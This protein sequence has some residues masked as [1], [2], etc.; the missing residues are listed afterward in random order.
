MKKIVLFFFSFLVLLSSCS[1]EDNDSN[2]EYIPFQESKGGLWGMISPDGKILFSDEF[3]NEPTVAKEGRFMVRNSSGLWE[4]YTCEAKPVKIGGE[5]VYATCFK[6]GRAIVAERNGY[7]KVIDRQG[8]DIKILDKINNH[9]VDYLNQFEEGCAVYM[10]DSLYGA[11]DEDFDEVIKPVYAELYH[12][13]DGKFIGIHDKYRKELDKPEAER[14][15][16]YDVLNTKGDLLFQLSTEKY[17][18]FHESPYYKDGLLRVAVDVNGNVCYGLINDKGEFVV[19]PQEKIKYISEIDGDRFIYSNGEGYG[20]MDLK[21]N[22]LIRAKY[23]YLSFDIQNRLFAGTLTSKDSETSYYDRTFI[24]KIIDDHDKQIGEDKYEEF[25]P[26]SKINGKRAF[27][28]TYGNIWSIIDTNGKTLEG[29]PDIVNINPLSI[30]DN[31]I[32]TDHIDFDELLSK[33]QL[34]KDGIDGLSFK[35]TVRDAV[36]KDLKNW[37]GRMVR[38]KPFDDPQYY[39]NSSSVSYSVNISDIPIKICV[40]FPGEMSRLKYRTVEY[41]AY[42]FFEGTRYATEKKVPDGYVFNDYSAKAFA[43]IFPNSYR[44]RGKLRLLLD[45]LKKKFGKYGKLEK[46]NSGAAVYSIDKNNRVFMFMKDNE[47]MLLWG[48][49]SD[50]KSLNIDEYKNVKEDLNCLDEFPPLGTP[51]DFLKCG[52]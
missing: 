52:N 34:S 28:K 47:V 20:V 2:V 1:K 16:K 50:V 7:I 40:I 10:T 23:D 46:E 30:G 42:S 25:I 38:E 31:C 29:L 18:Y 24:K 21:S 35:S 15:L 44:M 39:Y 12:C 36:K 3:K 19:K 13:S 11:I 6:N 17:R 4:I 9:Q 5:Y 37:E 43:V 45:C 26:F 27:V 48:N 51:E 22:V 33:L 41:Y 32:E 14:V 49:I 8:N